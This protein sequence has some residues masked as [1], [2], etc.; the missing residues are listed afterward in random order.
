MSIFEVKVNENPGQ[1]GAA[2]CA[3]FCGLSSGSG[4]GSG[5]NELELVEATQ[6]LE[7]SEEK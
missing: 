3:C 5:I 4:S 2:G 6:N 1:R 7:K